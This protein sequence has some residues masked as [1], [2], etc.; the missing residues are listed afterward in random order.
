MVND[1]RL[2]KS[3]IVGYQNQPFVDRRVNKAEKQKLLEC[4]NYVE[5]IGLG[6]SPIKELDGLEDRQWK[7]YKFRS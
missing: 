5:S 1:S 6:L 3:T 2:S 7:K 4:F